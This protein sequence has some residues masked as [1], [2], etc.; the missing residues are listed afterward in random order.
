VPVSFAIDAYRIVEA[1]AGQDV[2]SLR[3]P[4]RPGRNVPLYC[5]L[6]TDTA[7]KDMSGV[8]NVRAK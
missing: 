1:R 7:C 3:V 8:L 2:G 5:N 6:T 4:R